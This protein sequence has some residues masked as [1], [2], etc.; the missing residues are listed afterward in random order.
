M[1]RAATTFVGRTGV[2][3]GLAESLSASTANSSP[4][5]PRAA[6]GHGLKLYSKLSL[7]SPLAAPRSD[8]ASW[9]PSQYDD[10]FRVYA[11]GSEDDDEMQ[12]THFQEFLLGPAPSSDE[13]HRAVSALQQLS[14]FLS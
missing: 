5:S 11:N 9:P 6:S 3:G 2:T 4:T 8:S 10:Y 13:V 7:S 14:G 1:L 12:K